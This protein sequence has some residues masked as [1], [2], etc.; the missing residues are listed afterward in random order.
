[1]QL[2]SEIHDDNYC[3]GLIV[4]NTVQYNNTMQVSSE[5]PTHNTTPWL[6]RTLYFIP[7]HIH[8]AE[9]I[10]STMNKLYLVNCNV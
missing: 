3:T 9:T 10:I 8:P 4:Y 7:Q 2:L 1:M 6:F 5:I